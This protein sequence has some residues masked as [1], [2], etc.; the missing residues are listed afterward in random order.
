MTTAPFT[1]ETDEASEGFP[2]AGL[3]WGSKGGARWCSSRRSAGVF[4]KFRPPS[5]RVPNPHH[6]N[7]A[8]LEPK[9]DSVGTHQNFSNRPVL[10]FRN[11][12]G[13]ITKF[14]DLFATCND[15]PPRRQGRIGIVESD[16]RDDASQVTPSRRRPDY[17]RSHSLNSVSTF[18][19]GIPSPASSSAK[20]RLI[21]ELSVNR[22][23]TSCQSAS[24]G[25]SSIIF[26]A[27]SFTLMRLAYASRAFLQFQFP[28]PFC[29]PRG[30]FFICAPA[31]SLSFR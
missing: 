24:S 8:R 18:S 15:T 19:T 3:R 2:F 14:L 31:N 1:R 11:D 25:S 4:S 6:F 13:G 30:E 21:A 23:I 10:E 17:R 9:N 22:S 5:G 27:I 20:P 29:G 12:P 16:V 26:M 7:P 28:V